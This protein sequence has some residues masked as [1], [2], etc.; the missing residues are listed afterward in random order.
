M[1]RELLSDIL[2]IVLFSVIVFGG[3]GMLVNYL[4]SVS[5]EKKAEALGKEHKYGFFTGCLVEIEE[6]VY[7]NYKNY[8]VNVDDD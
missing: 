5:C 7:I 8:R 6:D 1:N 2:F 3:A 4:A